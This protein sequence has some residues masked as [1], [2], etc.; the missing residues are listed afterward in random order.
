LESLANF[1]VRFKTPEV[2]HCVYRTIESIKDPSYMG[3]LADNLRRVGREDIA[4][5]LVGA[6]DEH[7][8]DLEAL[9]RALNN[10]KSV[11]SERG[12]E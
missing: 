1:L 12:T 11:F 8:V 6:P 10:A 3:D 2:N 5:L 7:P 4:D 9:R